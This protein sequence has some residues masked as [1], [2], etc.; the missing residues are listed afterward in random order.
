MGMFI[1]LV[2]CGMAAGFLIA[3]AYYKS[4]AWYLQLDNEDLTAQ[5]ATLT[6][7]I[8]E[9]N[10]VRWALESKVEGLEASVVRGH[11]QVQQWQDWE[12]L[13]RA[14][15]QNLNEVIDGEA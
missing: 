10:A 14:A 5:R 15:C 9:I 6:K 2:S 13:V 4:E 1:A 12:V 8:D 11:E 7:R 3:R